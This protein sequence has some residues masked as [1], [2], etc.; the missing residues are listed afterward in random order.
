ML[1]YSYQSEQIWYLHDESVECSMILPTLWTVKYHVKTWQ[2]II[3][4]SI[5]NLFIIHAFANQCSKHMHTLTTQKHIVISCENWVIHSAESDGG[6]CSHISIITQATD[7][8][9]QIWENILVH[10]GVQEHYNSNYWQS[11]ANGREHS[12][13]YWCARAS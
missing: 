6:P 3:I 8:V 10:T 2:Q 13:S 11:V 7:R 4:L 9:W 1:L 5:C 12:C